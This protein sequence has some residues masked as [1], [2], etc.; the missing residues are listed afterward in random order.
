MKKFPLDLLIV[1][2]GVVLGYMLMDKA[3]G[4]SYVLGLGLFLQIPILSLVG[5]IWLDRVWR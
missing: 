1:G 2:E 4:L 5:L 3:S